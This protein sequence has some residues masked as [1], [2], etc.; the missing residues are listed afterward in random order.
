MEKEG[1]CIMKKTIYFLFFLA[2]DFIISTSSYAFSHKGIILDGYQQDCTIQVQNA[3]NKEKEEYEC[4]LSRLLFP[5]YKV[6]KKPDAKALRIKWAPYAR[7]EIKDSTTLLVVFDPPRNKKDIFSSILEYMGFMKTS[8]SISSSATA[9]R[10]TT[11]DKM[12]GGTMEGMPITEVGLSEVANSTTAIEPHDVLYPN[13]FATILPGQ[14]VDFY[15]GSKEGE[16]IIFEDSAG[17]EIFKKKVK[18]IIHLGL[19]PE[20]IGLKFGETYTWHVTGLRRFKKH[21]IEILDRESYQQ[22]LS[23]LNE[24][25][26]DKEPSNSNE[27]ALKKAAYLDLL[28]D[29]YPEKINLYWMSYQVL[30]GISEDTLSPE[31]KSLRDA[32][33]KNCKK[34]QIQ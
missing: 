34:R 14:M 16:N 23:D 33:I 8:R 6:I 15:W 9:C 22:V 1:H 5:G 18:S 28:S 10:E 13:N 3:T 20:E 25:D 24:I 26:I 11:S 19:T 17:A 12:A 7:G 2:F 27:R 30:R 4:V 31:N 32:L 21:R 29:S